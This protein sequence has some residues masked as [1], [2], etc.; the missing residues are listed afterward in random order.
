MATGDSLFIDEYIDEFP[1]KSSIP[2]EFPSHVYVCQV[3]HV[4]TAPSRPVAP[5]SASSIPVASCEP[6]S[7]D[8]QEEALV[9]KKNKTRPTN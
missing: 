4:A 1:I 3:T 6:A 7:F 8:H 9:S 2:T 5:V